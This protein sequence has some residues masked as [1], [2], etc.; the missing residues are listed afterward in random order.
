MLGLNQGEV[1]KNPAPLPRDSEERMSDL[2]RYSLINFHRYD[3]NTNFLLSAS[4]QSD[5]LTF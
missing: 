4:Y 3:S 5:L 1:L 2:G